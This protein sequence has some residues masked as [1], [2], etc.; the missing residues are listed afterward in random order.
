MRLIPNDFERIKA[1]LKIR[2]HRLCDKKRAL[3]K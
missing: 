2:E 3:L 1:G